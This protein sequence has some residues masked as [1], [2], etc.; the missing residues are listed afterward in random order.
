[1]AGVVVN[2]LMEVLNANRLC[3][4]LWGIDLRYEYRQ[5]VERNLLSVASTPRFAD[6]VLNWDEAVASGVGVVKDHFEKEPEGTSPYYVAVMRHFQAGD[7]KYIKRFL[8]VWERTPAHPSKVAWTYKVVWDEPGIGVMRFL[9]LV[10]VGSEPD[11]FGWN[12]WIPIDSES[13]SRLE[14]LKAR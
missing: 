1:M 10:N 7:P 12:D 4:K 2:T 8:D 6:R 3:Q 9:S 13:W 11:G 14:A 5:P